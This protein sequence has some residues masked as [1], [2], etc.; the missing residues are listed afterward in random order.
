MC[1]GRSTDPGDVS[2]AVRA[3]GRKSFYVSG[4]IADPA[5]CSHLIE[6]TVAELGSID[7]LVNNAGIIR[8][9]RRWIIPSNPGTKY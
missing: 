1:H 4:D 7:I 8:R 3:L 9:A 6:T 2:A 5:A